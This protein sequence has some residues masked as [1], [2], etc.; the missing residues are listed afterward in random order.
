MKIYKKTMNKYFATLLALFIMYGVQAQ[1]YVILPDSKYGQVIDNQSSYIP[2]SVTLEEEG[3]ENPYTIAVNYEPTTLDD[4]EKDIKKYVY[5]NKEKLNEQ[6]PVML[7]IDKD[8][9]FNF[10]AELREELKRMYL[11][12]IVIQVAAKDQAEANKGIPIRLAK[13][14][15]SVHEHYAAKKGVKPKTAV[16]FKHIMA[17]MPEEVKPPRAPKFPAVTETSDNYRKFLVKIDAK[18]KMYIGYA[19][20]EAKWFYTELDRKMGD[21]EKSSVIVRLHTADDV[22]FEKYINTVAEI[23]EVARG[24]SKTLVFADYSF[25]EMDY[26]EDIMKD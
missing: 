25:I 9:P 6:L 13:F 8:I 11:N 18:E 20:V 12:R 17:G 15:D 2:I 3:E 16:T 7:R 24:K 5:R 23:N 10:Y 19:P 21:I 1:D 26:I 14:Y 22:S 4:L